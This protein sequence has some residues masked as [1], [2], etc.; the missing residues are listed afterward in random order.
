MDP[1]ACGAYVTGVVGIITAILTYLAQKRHGDAS[2]ETATTG[3]WQAVTDAQGEALQ[4][5]AE[6]LVRVREEEGR[7]RGE[8][9]KTRGE[10]DAV[11]TGMGRCLQ[12]VERW[13]RLLLEAGIDLDDGGGADAR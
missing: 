6:D 2:V 7:L 3:E 1:L 4:R 10:L 11:K 13:K 12:A 5:L 8:L 9:S